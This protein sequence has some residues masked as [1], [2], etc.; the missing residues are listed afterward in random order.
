MYNIA[1]KFHLFIKVAI[2]WVN[3]NTSQPS[4]LIILKRHSNIE[5]YKGTTEE[6]VSVILCIAGIYPQSEKR[7]NHGTELLL[8]YSHLWAH[9]RLNMPSGVQS[10]WR[11]VKDETPF[12]HSLAGIWTV[13][14]LK[15][16][17]L[18]R[19]TKKFSHV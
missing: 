5:I 18:F 12:R 15:K 17:I 3:C 11:K 19:E 6:H 13:L 10:V 9:G 8:Y 7:L 2:L 1:I 4:L 14:C 16:L